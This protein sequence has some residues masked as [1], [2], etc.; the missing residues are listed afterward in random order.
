MDEKTDKWTDGRMDERTDSR[1]DTR[2]DRWT[3]GGTNGWTGGLTDGPTSQL[4]ISKICNGTNTEDTF[5]AQV[6]FENGSL[7]W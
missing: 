7:F 2:T 6:K 4:P 3:K 1:A 5:C